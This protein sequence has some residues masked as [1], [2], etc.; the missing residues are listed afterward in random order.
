MRPLTRC[1][2]PIVGT[3]MPCLLGQPCPLR[4]AP[5]PERAEA[6]VERPVLAE[7]ARHVRLDRSA[8]ANSSRPSRVVVNAIEASTSVSCGCGA[9]SSGAG[10]RRRGALPGL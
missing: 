6:P 4:H 10:L 1:D 3:I 8:Q 7:A 2:D 5:L 9:A